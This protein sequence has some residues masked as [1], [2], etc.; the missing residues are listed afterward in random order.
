VKK[1][2]YSFI[3]FSL[4][5]TFSIIFL[6]FA[7]R[8]YSF[9]F[10]KNFCAISININKYKSKFDE[11]VGYVPTS[12]KKIGCNKETYLINDEGFRN[13]TGFDIIKSNILIVGDSFG[14]GDEVSDNETISFYLKK[15]HN[16]NTINAAVYGYGL[17]QALIRAK[18]ISNYVKIKNVIL[19]IAPGGYSRT[20]TIERN[21]IEKPYYEIDFNNNIQLIKPNKKKFDYSS[22]NNFLE[23]SLLFNY[24]A[25]KINFTEIIVNEKKNKNDPVFIGCKILSFYKKE[26]ENNKIS[27]NVL[28]YRD[29]SEILLEDSSNTKSTKKFLECLN[30]NNI[31][32]IDTYSVLKKNQNKKLYVKIKYGH[33]T[34]FSNEIVSK[35]IANEINK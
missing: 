2:I 32:Y 1:T 24:V 29:A 23:K 33:P 13:Y 20:N 12:G 9:I 27:L 15:N 22:R 10:N 30:R 35:L 5:I 11:N 8:A 26:F 7:G 18:Q 28:F 4:L 14:F 3:I 25:N 16:I 21:G 17:D 31:K 34:A 19:I 6:E